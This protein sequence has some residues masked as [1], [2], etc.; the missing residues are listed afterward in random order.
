M[1]S[2]MLWTVCLWLCLK[3]EFWM[4]FDEDPVVEY[5]LFLVDIITKLL[6]ALCAF[7]ID[8]DFDSGLAEAAHFQ[9]GL[10]L[11]GIDYALLRTVVVLTFPPTRRKRGK[12]AIRG[13]D[14][15]REWNLPRNNSRWHL[16]DN[17]EGSL[18][19][20]RLNLRVTHETFLQI[21]R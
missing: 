7:E 5:A 11:M 4:Q 15:F 18:E 12:N 6:V 16:S 8:E 2:E 21:V 17:A 10:Q 1:P 13:G 20:F 14:L 3:F 19:R 9:R